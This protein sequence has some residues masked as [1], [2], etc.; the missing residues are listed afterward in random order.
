MIEVS[1]VITSYN[2][3]SDVKRAVGSA[4]TQDYPE[5]LFELVIVDDGSSDDTVKIINDTL[6]KAN[7][8][9][10][11][12][13]VIEKENGGTA[14]ARNVGVK[15]SLGKYIGFLDADDAYLKDKIS[16]SVKAFEFGPNIGIVYS[17][18][19]SEKQNNPND[20]GLNMKFPYSWS[21]LMLKCIVSSNSFVLKEAVE[22]VGGFDESFELIEDYDL[23]VR[24]CGVGY[25]ARHI[26]KHLFIYNDRDDNKTNS[27]AKNNFKTHKHESLRLKEK[28]LDR[29]FYV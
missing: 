4:L 3:E 22:K 17:D 25:M 11:K 6:L 16:E 21:R 7:T 5:D 26:P 20:K 29:D 24:V 18:Y 1:I 14:S 19:V 12:T 10:I 8:R 27:D 23:W 15:N 13:T 28:V 9:G 2:N